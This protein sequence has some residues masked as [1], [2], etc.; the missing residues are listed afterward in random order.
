MPTET[1]VTLQDMAETYGVA[2]RAGLITPCLQDE[3]VFRRKLGLPPAP[4][5][6]ESD[7]AKGKGVRRP[8]TLTQDEKAKAHPAADD[9]DKKENEGDNE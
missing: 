9:A 1:K 5:E 3:N 8:I 6:V 4:A 2:V 7:W